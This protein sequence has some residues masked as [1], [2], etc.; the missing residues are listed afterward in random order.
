MNDSAPNTPPPP[1]GDGTGPAKQPDVVS[2]VGDNVV[3]IIAEDDGDHTI[4]PAPDHVRRI[5]R[6]Y[7]Q[8]MPP[9]DAIGDAPH[10]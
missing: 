5:L 7:K 2:L 9:P 1:S 4:Q 3:T 6:Q 8:R 10:S